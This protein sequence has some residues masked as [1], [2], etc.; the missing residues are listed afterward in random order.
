MITV[1]IVD[2]TITDDQLNLAIDTS[3]DGSEPIRIQQNYATTMTAVEIKS[4]IDSAVSLLWL[5]LENPSWTM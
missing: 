3:Q 2:A 5:A 1:T 4:A